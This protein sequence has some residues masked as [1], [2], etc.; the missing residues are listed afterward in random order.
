MSRLCKEMA[1][2]GRGFLSLAFN[3]LATF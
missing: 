1:L 2:G 3:V